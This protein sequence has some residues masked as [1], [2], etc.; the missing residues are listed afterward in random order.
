MLIFFCFLSSQGVKVVTASECWNKSLEPLM[1]EV[2]RTAEGKPVYI[3]F[4]IDGLDPS[5]APGTGMFVFTNS[6]SF[7][8]S[9]IVRFDRIS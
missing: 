2:R 1:K 7:Y 4:D 9:Y 5:F 6:K 8:G 3:S